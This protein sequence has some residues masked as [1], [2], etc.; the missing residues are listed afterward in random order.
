MEITQVN[1]KIGPAEEDDQPRFELDQV[2][3]DLPDHKA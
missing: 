1:K 2:G 3:D